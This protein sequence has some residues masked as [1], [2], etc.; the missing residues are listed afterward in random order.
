MS[1]SKLSENTVIYM[2]KRHFGLLF[3]AS[4]LILIMR[5]QFR[6]AIKVQPPLRDALEM[7]LGCTK[8]LQIRLIWFKKCDPVLSRRASGRRVVL[9]TALASISAARMVPSR[10]VFVVW[11]VVFGLLFDCSPPSSCV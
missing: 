2:E 3:M 9:S 6:L 8:S 10:P 7:F 11:V 5:C 4:G 1:H